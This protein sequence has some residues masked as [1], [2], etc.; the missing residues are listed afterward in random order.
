MSTLIK[1]SDRQ[2]FF[3]VFEELDAGRIFVR[4]CN[5]R[6]KLRWRETRFNTLLC[7]LRKEGV[8]QLH[9]GDFFSLSKEDIALSFTDENGFFYVTLTMKVCNAN[10]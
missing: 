3:K 7:Q 9:S 6:R 5:M 10:L 4:I 8:I 1:Q 2:R